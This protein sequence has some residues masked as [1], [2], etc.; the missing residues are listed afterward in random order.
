M[1]NAHNASKFRSMLK[2]GG[3]RQ[4]SFKT[5]ISIP[6]ANTGV[7]EQFSFLCTSGSVPSMTLGTA[8]VHYF[9]RAI[10][11]AGDR[12]FEPYT[13][14]LIEDESFSVRNALEAWQNAMNLLNQDTDK[15]SNM[16]D[17]SQY[18][19]DVR[20][21]PIGVDGGAC[22]LNGAGGVLKTYTLKN[23]FP[24]SIGAIEFGY[25]N[26]NSV[27]SYQVTFTYDYFTTSEI[28]ETK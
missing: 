19:V 22:G 28:K 18:Y 17:H 11:F 16:C 20:F 2:H 15:R 9:G 24:S 1:S 14:T 26:N 21:E 3:L 23:A 5:T 4:N 13:V 8:T 10:N 12:E 25:E 7:D 27:A 6:N